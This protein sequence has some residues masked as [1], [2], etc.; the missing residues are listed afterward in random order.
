VVEGN[1]ER[2]HQAGLVAISSSGIVPAVCQE[3]V[4]IISPGVV[5]DLAVGERMGLVNR[6]APAAELEKFVLDYAAMIAGNAPLTIAAVKR[7]RAR[8]VVNDNI[9]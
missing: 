9:R 5:V 8:E 7:T 3:I 6:V 4:D 1:Q 2:G